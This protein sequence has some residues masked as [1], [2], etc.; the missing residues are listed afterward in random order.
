MIIKN[1]ILNRNRDKQKKT[2]FVYG[3]RI[4]YS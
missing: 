4:R 1:F 3:N 2:E